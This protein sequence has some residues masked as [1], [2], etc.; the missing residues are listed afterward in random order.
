[1]I[2]LGRV[3]REA[4]AGVRRRLGLFENVGNGLVPRSMRVCTARDCY[5]CRERGPGPASFRLVYV[6]PGWDAAS[7]GN[8]VIYQHVKA[9]AGTGVPGFVFHPDSPGVSHTSM[10]RNVSSLKM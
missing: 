6:C 3:V 2:A 9:I 10:G 5:T 1:M 4:R 8:N 7:G